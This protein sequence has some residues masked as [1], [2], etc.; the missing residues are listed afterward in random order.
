MKAPTGGHITGPPLRGE[1]PPPPPLCWSLQPAEAR[2]AERGWAAP[3]TAEEGKP[4]VKS[5]KEQKQK[6][7]AAPARSS[8][9]RKQKEEEEQKKKQEEEEE[10]EEEWD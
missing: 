4:K 1:R 6:P 3:A 2:A 7:A 9:R 8:G 10:E 5:G